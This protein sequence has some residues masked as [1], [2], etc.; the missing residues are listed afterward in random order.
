MDQQLDKHHLTTIVLVA[1]MS[2]WLLITSECMA[3]T[4]V[5]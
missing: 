3:F 2:L 1:S 5:R 4:I